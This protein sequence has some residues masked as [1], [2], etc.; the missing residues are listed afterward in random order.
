MATVLRRKSSKSI[1]TTPIAVGAYTAPSVATG[2]FVTGLTISNTL[3]STSVNVRVDVFDATTHFFL[4][5]DAPVPVGGSISLADNGHRLVLNGGD[6]I[7]V[8]SSAS[9]SLD[10]NMS[11]SEIT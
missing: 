6:Q 5:V 3:P 11:V 1:G 4:C 8:S 2:V 10:V 7:F 9:S